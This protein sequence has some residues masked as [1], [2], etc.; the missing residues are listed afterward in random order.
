MGK[1]ITKREVDSIWLMLPI[2]MFCFHLNIIVCI[3]FLNTSFI[4]PHMHAE[5][6]CPYKFTSSLVQGSTNVLALRT[7]FCLA[8]FCSPAL[9]K[10]SEYLAHANL[11]QLV[12]HH[13][14]D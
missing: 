5:I 2:N 12:S 9:N 6:C 11:L 10:I 7:G 14:T 1:R 4:H 3:Y 8:L 13:D